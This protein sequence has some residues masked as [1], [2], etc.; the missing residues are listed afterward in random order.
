MI[1]SFADG[2]DGGQLVD[3][4]I[5]AAIEESTECREGLLRNAGANFERVI[6]GNFRNG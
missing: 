3:F 4:D 2:D 1:I 5:G 6:V